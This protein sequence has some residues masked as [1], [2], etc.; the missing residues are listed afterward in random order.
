[1][2]IRGLTPPARRRPVRRRGSEFGRWVVNLPLFR[3]RVPARYRPALFFET[4]YNVGAGGFISLFLLSG[5]VLKTV[6]DGTEGHLAL[7]AAMFGGSSLLSPLVSYCGR[8]IPMRSLVVYPNLIVAALLLATGLTYGGPLLFTL[9]VGSAFI[10][11]VFPRVAEMNMYR[12]LYPATHRGA[13]VGWVK[14]VAA[15]SALL[16]TLIG[17]WWFSFQ[18]SRYWWLYGLVSVLLVSSTWCYTK[19]PISR[20]N[21]FAREDG[22]SPYQAFWEGLRI[23]LTDRR[24]LLY[25]MGFWFAG[26]GNHMAMVYVADALKE[27]VIGSRPLEELLPGFLH[28]LLTNTWQLERGTIVTLIVGFVFAV[29]PVLLMMTSAPFWG[30]FLDQTNPMIGRA[31]FNSIQCVA[32]A[33]HAYGGLTLQLW[34][35]LLGGA[36]HAVGNGGST[37]NWLTGSLYFAKSDRISLYNTVHVGLTGIRGLIAPLFGWYLYSNRGL[38]LGPGLFWIA[39]ILSLIGAVLMVWQGMTDPGSREKRT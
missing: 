6:I 31:V 21:V 19:I 15:V 33:L 38:G 1:L 28:T 14:A 3:D 16:V 18:P 2:N 39:S 27:T 30:R 20:R 25:Q 7:L 23:F 24:F 34:P 12:I 8:K 36:I 29:L 9:V 22:L 17:Y 13:A 37:I 10:M 32:F 5:V 26:F 4:F 35:M 11:R